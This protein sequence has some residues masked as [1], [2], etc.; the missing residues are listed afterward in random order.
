LQSLY[1][2]AN[3]I[4]KK[5]EAVIKENPTF[6]NVISIFN[7]SQA[8]LISLPIDN[9]G[10]TIEKLDVNQDQK[11]KL[12]HVTPSNHYPLVVKMSLIRR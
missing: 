6:P 11:P 3:A 2:I 1:L 10:I 12:I 8:N 4:L 5:G 9:E 7:S